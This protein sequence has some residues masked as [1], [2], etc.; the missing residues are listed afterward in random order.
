VRAGQPRPIAKTVAVTLGQ[1]YRGD[2]L[3]VPHARKVLNGDGVTTRVVQDELHLVLRPGYAAGYKLV[4]AQ[5]GDEGPAVVPADVIVTLKEASAADGYRRAGHDLIYTTRVALAV[6][7]RRDR[8]RARPAP[9]ARAA[10]ALRGRSLTKVRP[11]RSLALH[12]CSARR[13]CARAPRRTRCAASSCTCRRSTAARS[14]S[15]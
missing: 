9:R 6:S 10:G 11:G 4:F 7:E 2:S 8:R 12:V 1:L 5:K 14:L 13:R 15:G 3:T